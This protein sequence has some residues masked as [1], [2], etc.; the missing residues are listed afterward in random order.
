MKKLLSVIVGLWLATSSLAGAAPVIDVG[1]HYVRPGEPLH[2]IA[3]DVAG[4]D[5]VQ[6]MDCWVEIKYTG[7]EPD[8]PAKT[9]YILAVETIRAGSLFATDYD[10]SDT[11]YP[12][13]PAPSRIWNQ[14]TA[15]KPGVT[16]LAA[17]TVA[18][19]D[20][21]TIATT[22]LGWKFDLLLKGVAVSNDW[23]EG[24]D[25]QFSY[26]YE[27]PAV[28]T[29][30][31]IVMS[32]WHTMSW[33]KPGDGLWFEPGANPW[34]DDSSFPAPAPP[35]PSYPNYTADVRIETP[36]TVTI[37]RYHASRQARSLLLSGGAT[38][39]IEAPRSL[40]VTNHI[41][42]GQDSK[43]H[44]EPGASVTADVFNLTGGTLQLGGG[45]ATGSLTINRPL[46]VAAG[47]IMPAA[48]EDQI[49]ISGDLTLG[50]AAPALLTKAGAGLLLLAGSQSWAADAKIAVSAG[51]LRYQ[52]AADKTVSVA[53]GNR[54][55]ISPDAILE[56]AGEVAA[57]S[58]GASYVDVTNNSIAPGLKVLPGAI[59]QLGGIDGSGTTL[60]EPGA[61]LVAGSIYQ[62]ELLIGGTPEH[63]GKLVFRSSAGAGAQLAVFI[64]SGDGS[65]A[66]AQS[67][68]GATA[69]PEPA[70]GVMLAA[71]AISVAAV[72]AGRAC[73]ASR[74]RCGA[75][76]GTLPSLPN[77]A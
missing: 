55:T 12:D 50:G 75:F 14:D 57:L 20:V 24:L 77:S 23:P 67:A 60:V 1:V 13:P 42:I 37:D 22:P 56:L 74:R 8:G 65:P 54:I 4:G 71:L 2:T 31:A 34:S 25:T 17:G 43:L 10:Y 66:T 15:L 72:A 44:L 73:L 63:P 45:S 29:N 5:I 68:A 38:L 49:T 52:L 26:I 48:A 70:A 53:A 47:A 39:R 61:T 3:I 28:I 19:I 32:D 40:T 36:H 69:V 64:S 16:V 21:Q 58:D 59:Q 33:S 9:P 27:I 51:K 11:L 41:T 7:S 76:R 35:P 6:A 46:N 30:G 18:F 62:S